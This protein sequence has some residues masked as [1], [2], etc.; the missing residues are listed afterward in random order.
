MIHDTKI[1]ILLVQFYSVLRPLLSYG[2]IFCVAEQA[3]IR[4]T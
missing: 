1:Q 4:L 2:R 3:T